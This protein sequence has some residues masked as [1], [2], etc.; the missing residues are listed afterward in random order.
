MVPI[1]TCLFTRLLTVFM[2]LS[3]FF[4]GMM[5]VN[6]PNGSYRKMADKINLTATAY[7]RV[8]KDSKVFMSLS[9]F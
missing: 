6:R 8:K 9:F 5:C 1:G 2:S 4:V 3:F 7:K